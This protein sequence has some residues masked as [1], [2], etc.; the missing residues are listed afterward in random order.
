MA[1]RD[2]PRPRGP[3]ILARL[4]GAALVCALLGGAS[5]LVFNASAQSQS[6]QEV[7]KPKKAKPTPDPA[8]TPAAAAAA[9]PAQS[10]QDFQVVTQLEQAGVKRCLPAVN[11]LARFE[12]SGVTE[13]ASS[14]TWH[15]G[16]PDN[17]LFTS[18]IGQKFGQ[19]ASTPVGLSGVV[20]APGA[21]G[22][23]DAVGFQI[24]PTAASCAT[25]QAQ[26]LSKGQ[27]IGNLVGVPVLRD[28]QNL[29]L[30]LLP[31]AGNGCV[32]VALNNY[33]AD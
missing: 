8:A 12:M 22:K 23:C 26:I 25:I 11:D 10:A 32:I 7:K 33:Y 28:A 18:V 4:V 9:A 27:L 13:Y 3:R 21:V 2:L 5:Q 1:L 24:L 14:A 20:S 19:N 16:E 6:D 30:M 31:A 15:K 29:R 17:R